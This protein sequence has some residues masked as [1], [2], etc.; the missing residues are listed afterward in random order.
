MS[1]GH[2]PQVAPPMAYTYAILID[3]YDRARHLDLALGFFGR[4]LS[5][6]MGVDLVTFGN[7]PSSSA[8]A[9]QGGQRRPPTCCSARCLSLHVSLM[10]SCTRGFSNA[11]VMIKRVG[12]HLSRSG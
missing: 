7:L 4:L 10:L 8:F 5:T 9:T 2:G 1:R 12:G 3:Y 6:G 11:S